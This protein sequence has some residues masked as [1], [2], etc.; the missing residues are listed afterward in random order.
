MFEMSLRSTPRRSSR[1]M[2]GDTVRLDS[3]TAGRMQDSGHTAKA[4]VA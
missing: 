2:F 3:N 1:L 4:M